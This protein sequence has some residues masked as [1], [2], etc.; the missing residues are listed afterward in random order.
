M[1]E[2]YH[3]HR[4]T[5]MCAEGDYRHCHRRLL[6]DHLVAKGPTSCQW[7]VIFPCSH[8]DT[9]P[10][11]RQSCYFLMQHF[12]YFFPLPHG[13]GAFLPTRFASGSDLSSKGSLEEG[14]LETEEVVFSSSGS[15]D[16]K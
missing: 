1:K 5:I 14:R 3:G 2:T 12:L 6:S 13:H 15:S 8:Q 9:K 11:S 10:T 7:P 4:T 16:G